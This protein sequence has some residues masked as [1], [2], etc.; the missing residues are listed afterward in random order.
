MRIPIR[1]R[2]ILQALLSEAYIPRRERYL[3]GRISDL[4]YSYDILHVYSGKSYHWSKLC[5]YNWGLLYYSHTY[6]ATAQTALL[7]WH[8]GRC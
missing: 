3:P 1:L 7:L 6:F 2:E 8:V 4:L 5:W